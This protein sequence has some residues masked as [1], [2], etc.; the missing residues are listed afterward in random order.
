MQLRGV[1]FQLGDYGRNKFAWF[2]RRMELTGEENLPR[3]SRFFTANRERE[4]ERGRALFRDAIINR[5][6]RLNRNGIRAIACTGSIISR[7]DLQGAR[8]SFN[9]RIG[10]SI[11]AISFIRPFFL[12]P[13]ALPTR[14]ARARG[15][16]RS[17]GSALAVVAQLLAE[18]LEI[19]SLASIRSESLSRTINTFRPGGLTR[20]EV[21]IVGKFAKSLSLADRRAQYRGREGRNKVTR[22]VVAESVDRILSG[23]STRRG[24]KEEKTMEG[25]EHR[26][27]ILIDDLSLNPPMLARRHALSADSCFSTSCFRGG[28]GRGGGIRE[29]ETR[30][31]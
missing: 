4:R 28:R 9:A 12:L 6:D 24:R 13:T 23:Q 15:L 25:H 3:S 20:R 18:R 5:Y 26:T 22:D 7:T 27:A 16:P 10:V 1:R 30:Y 17:R 29:G 21:F 31:A 8:G 14:L 19:R 11:I 2:L